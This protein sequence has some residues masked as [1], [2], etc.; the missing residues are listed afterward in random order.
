MSDIIL[1]AQEEAERKRKAREAG[2]PESLTETA[3][4]RHLTVMI[5]P[6]ES[7]LLN[8]LAKKNGR[9]RSKEAIE[10]IKEKAQREGVG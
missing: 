7:E 6:A 5:Q 9:S 4:A 1:R 3:T 10:A 8:K 2:R